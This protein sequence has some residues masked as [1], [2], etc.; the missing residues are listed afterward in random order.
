MKKFI[1]IFVFIL[2]SCSN[3]DD[4]V[5]FYDSPSPFDYGWVNAEK[6]GANWEAHSWAT[7]RRRDEVWSY[8]SLVFTLYNQDGFILELFSIEGIPKEEGTY[9]ITNDPEFRVVEHAKG[10]YSTLIEDGHIM[11]NSYNVDESFL[12]INKIAVSEFKEETGEIWGSFNVELKKIDI[13]NCDPDAQG[14]I[15]F[16]NAEFYAKII[17]Q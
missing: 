3:D 10:Y 4:E 17:N 6:N 9:N 11:C 14:I 2:F 16:T 8:F 15:S 12:D 1:F 13:T 7:D 5:M